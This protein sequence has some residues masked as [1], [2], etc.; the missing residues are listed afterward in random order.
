MAKLTLWDFLNDRNLL[1]I[2]ISSHDLSGFF[3]KTI[4]VPLNTAGLALFQDGTTALFA[5][6]TEVT[7]HFDL[8]LAKRGECSLRLA[9]SDLRTADGLGLSV[10]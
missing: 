9:F 6:G 3:R 2:K 5:E 10:T 1:A 8:V 4:T 7:G